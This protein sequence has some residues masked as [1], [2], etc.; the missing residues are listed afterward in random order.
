M[1]VLAARIEDVLDQ[2]ASRLLG[3]RGLG[4]GLLLLELLLLLLVVV[5]A[6]A[7]MV[8]VV[9]GAKDG[10]GDAALMGVARADQVLD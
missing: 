6:E 7:G 3:F 5:L 2:P 9:R 4:R 10:R 1:V 8:L